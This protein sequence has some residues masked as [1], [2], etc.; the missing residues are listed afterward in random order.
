MNL[1]CLVALIIYPEIL[2]FKEIQINITVRNEAHLLHPF[3]ENL[4]RQ[5]FF[6]LFFPS[7][8]FHVFTS[9]YIFHFDSRKTVSEREKEREGERERKW[10]K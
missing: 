2:F 10:A 3:K 9:F 7:F 5:T 6:F 1:N 8:C 4:Q